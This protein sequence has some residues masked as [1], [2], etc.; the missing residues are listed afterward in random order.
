MSAHV[1]MASDIPLPV[2]DE[3]EG[4]T[5]FCNLNIVSGLLESSSMGD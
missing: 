1:V 5:S 2:F 3:E 4:K